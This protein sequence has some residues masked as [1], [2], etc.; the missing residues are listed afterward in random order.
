MNG[1]DE[2][3]KK[4][5]VTIVYVHGAG[6]SSRVWSMQLSE[7]V[8]STGTISAPPSR[9]AQKT[10]PN[11]LAANTHQIALNLNGHGT[12]PDRQPS[13]VTES[14][15]EDIDAVVSSCKKP[16][17]VGHSMGGAL[18]RLYALKNPEKLG[19]LVLVGTGA[20]LKVAP[21]IFDFLDKNPLILRRHAEV[22]VLRKHS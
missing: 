6:G 11:A 18:S 22:H 5:Q 20:R 12:T 16:I 10:Q 8:S 13:D 4:N 1:I 7:R 15:L 21:M 14:Y 3:G 2:S 19:G 17:L 9:G